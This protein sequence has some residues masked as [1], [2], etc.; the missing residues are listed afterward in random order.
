[1][2]HPELLVVPVLMLIDYFLIGYC[3]AQRELA[4]DRYFKVELTSRYLS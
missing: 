2:N 3:A 1:M 4:Y